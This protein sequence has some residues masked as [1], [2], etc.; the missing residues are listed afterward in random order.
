MYLAHHRYPGLSVL[1]KIQAV[2]VYPL[3]CRVHA[4][5]MKMASFYFFFFDVFKCVLHILPF[6]HTR[7]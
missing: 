7:L 4:S 3:S 2:Y 5:K 1:F 6:S